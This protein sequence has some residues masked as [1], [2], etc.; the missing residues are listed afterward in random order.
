MPLAW[1]NCTTP[2]FGISLGWTSYIW[3]CIPNHGKPFRMDP[4]IRPSK[5]PTILQFFWHFTPSKPNWKTCLE[6]NYRSIWLQ[7]KWKFIQKYSLSCKIFPIMIKNYEY[8]VCTQC[9][10]G[11]IGCLLEDEDLAQQH[12]QQQLQLSTEQ[13]IWSEIWWKIKWWVRWWSGVILVLVK[14]WKMGEWITKSKI[15]SVNRATGD[16]S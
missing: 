3:G 9:F 11:S 15:S 12:R 5:T 1:Q 8:R 13:T 7:W 16:S 14:S 10:F 6:R 2:L 4:N